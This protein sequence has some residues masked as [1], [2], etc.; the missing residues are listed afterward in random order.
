MQPNTEPIQINSTKYRINSN[1]DRI[2]PNKID[3]E[4]IRMHS[5]F[6]TKITKNDE[7]QQK[8]VKNDKK[9]PLQNNC[10]SIQKREKQS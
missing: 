8:M 1:K 3:P 4:L 5:N 2:C 7:K 10:L 9:N 6:L